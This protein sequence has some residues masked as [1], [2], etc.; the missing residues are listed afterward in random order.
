M[1]KPST[2]TLFRATISKQE[3]HGKVQKDGPFMPTAY[4]SG[5]KTPNPLSITVL[6]SHGSHNETNKPLKPEKVMV[7]ATSER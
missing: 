7:N 6:T 1:K 2:N 4:R 5:K 3:L